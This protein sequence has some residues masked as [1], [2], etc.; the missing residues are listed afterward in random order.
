MAVT[1][2][3]LERCIELV[4]SS[5]PDPRVGLY[6]PSSMSW[7]VGRE[8][9]LFLSGGATTLLQLAHPFVA[10][11]VADHSATREDT[12]GRFLRTFENVYAMIFGTL[13]RAITSARRVHTIHERVTGTLKEAAGPRAAGSRYEAN[14]ERALFWVQ[15]TLIKNAVATFDLVV[16]KLSTS[17]KE[18]YFAESKQFGRLFGLEGSSRP[19]TWADFEAYYEGMLSSGELFVTQAAREMAE[20]LITPPHPALGPAWRWYVLITTGLLPPSLRD[21]YGLSFGSLERATFDASIAALRRTYLHLPGRLRHVPAYL[22]AEER[23]SAAPA[24]PRQTR[25][26]QG[27]R[28]PRHPLLKLF[29]RLRRASLERTR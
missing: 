10:Q 1:K 21:A 3:D 8:S 29:L 2:A 9:G 11:G 19:A 12:F 22:H 6:G 15:A 17:D 16:D 23:I 18:Q 4:R 13:D 24:K 27:D 20:F 25:S 26:S 28:D 7:R 5:T 14:D